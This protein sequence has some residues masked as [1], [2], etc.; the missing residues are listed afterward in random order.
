MVKTTSLASL[1]HH[2]GH[3][4]KS[5]CNSLFE[6]MFPFCNTCF[7]STYL[8]LFSLVRRRPEHDRKVIED[9]SECKLE[10]L[11]SAN[12]DRYY[13][14]LQNRPLTFSKIRQNC[15]KTC[16][17]KKMAFH[18]TIGINGNLKKIIHVACMDHTDRALKFLIFHSHLAWTEV[19]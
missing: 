5:L 17:K 18:R 14:L 1:F 3:R 12:Q 4:N 10:Q 19:N 8:A 7:Q 9:P 13:K 15:F 2:V 6:F 11:R 16:L